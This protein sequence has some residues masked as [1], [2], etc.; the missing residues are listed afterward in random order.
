[1]GAHG[2]YGAE[3]GIAAAMT[4]GPIWLA[5]GTVIVGTSQA[6]ANAANKKQGME[7]IILTIWQSK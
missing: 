1:M 3:L 5:L 4:G 2:A 6:M 7:V